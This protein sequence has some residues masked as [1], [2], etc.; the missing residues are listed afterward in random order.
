M[1]DLTLAA[2]RRIALP[3]HQWAHD[4]RNLLTTI[5]LH[6]DSLGA[7]V[8]S[9]RRQGGS[10]THTLIARAAIMCGEA[11]TLAEGEASRT[12]RHPFDITSTSA[13]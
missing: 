9:P 3:P 7:A 13:R 4:I 6:L 2:S 1:A 12:R 8:G 5:G 10:A 11:V